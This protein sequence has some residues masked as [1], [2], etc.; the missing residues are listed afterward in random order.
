MGKSKMYIENYWQILD[1]LGFLNKK[2]CLRDNLSAVFYFDIIYAEFGIFK[3]F[4]AE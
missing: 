2:Y 3:Y 4:A 1:F